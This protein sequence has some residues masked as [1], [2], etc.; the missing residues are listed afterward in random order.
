LSGSVPSVGGLDT[1]PGHGWEPHA[2]GVAEEGENGHCDGSFLTEIGSGSDVYL[3][4][5]VLTATVYL[6]LFMMI[7]SGT[8]SLLCLVGHRNRR[9]L[10]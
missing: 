6:S 10:S 1:S 4:S 9:V 7:V 3:G 2:S 8:L 5:V